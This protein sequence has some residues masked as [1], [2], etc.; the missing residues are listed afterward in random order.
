MHIKPVSVAQCGI[1]GCGNG[2]IFLAAQQLSSGLG[3]CLGSSNLLMGCIE[4]RGIILLHPTCS[5]SS[6]CLRTSFHVVLLESALGPAL[7][8]YCV[9]K[10]RNPEGA[11]A[12][13]RL[14]P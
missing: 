12:F 14:K 2:L 9:V 3:M 11:F 13:E 10:T 1:D 6:L 8:L 4:N 5:S 7:A